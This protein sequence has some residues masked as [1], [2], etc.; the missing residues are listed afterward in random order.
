VVL[1][2]PRLDGPIGFY[3]NLIL[4]ALA[5]VLLGVKN[6]I[7][8]RRQSAYYLFHL[9]LLVGT[10]S[11]FFLGSFSQIFLFIILFFLI[12]EFYFFMVRGSSELINLLAAAESVLLVQTA[13]V[14]SFFP[15]S[16]LV[17][18]SLLVLAAFVFHDALLNHLKGTF[19][20]QLAIRD[21]GVFVV[22]TGLIL[23]LP[24]WGFR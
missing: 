19:S 9:A 20:K 15:T 6:L 18:A 12:R 24:V 8:L 2:A 4:G 1:G 22:L 21:L 23:L 14:I 3:F 16:F 11:L 10:T 5:F 7:L 17:G 13:W